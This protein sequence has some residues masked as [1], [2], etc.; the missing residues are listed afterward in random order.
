MK[1]V[2]QTQQQA[3]HNACSQTDWAQIVY[4]GGPPCFDLDKGKFCLRAERWVGH[5]ADHKFISLESVFQERTAV[6][7]E[8]TRL[9][10]ENG[11]MREALVKLGAFDDQYA[12]DILE[13]RGNY[14]SFDE[15]EAVKVSRETL[16]ALSTPPAEHGAKEGRKANFTYRVE[17][18]D[19]TGSVNF[20]ID[21]SVVKQE[22]KP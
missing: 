4:N 21:E 11:K 7:A 5:D 6:L 10:A 16:A 17:R 3:L 2:K 1:K 13:Y 14:S 9:R 18:D 15:P 20:Q 8:N 12:G 19:K 22:T